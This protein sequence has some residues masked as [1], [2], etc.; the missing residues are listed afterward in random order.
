[1]PY[2]YVGHKCQNE[3][4][5]SYNTTIIATHNM[6]TFPLR[7]SANT[8]ANTTGSSVLHTRSCVSCLFIYDTIPKHCLPFI[9]ESNP[10][11]VSNHGAL[12]A[13]LDAAL[14][15]VEDIDEDEEEEEEEVEEEE[16]I[17][18]EDEGEGEAEGEEN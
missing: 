14:D 12:M 9:L 16:E 15:D 6:P 4:C 17:L 7:P 5:G 1:M 10:G 3:K 11:Q 2:H 18:S 13:L 8:S